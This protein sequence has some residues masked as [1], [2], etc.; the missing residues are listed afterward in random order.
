MNLIDV[1]DVVRLPIDL[2]GLGEIEADEDTASLPYTFTM[3]C[4]DLSE[5]LDRVGGGFLGA[6][7]IPR[8]C[9][10]RSPPMM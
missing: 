7:P 8:Y 5:T 9:P 10:L 3:P 1:M 2:S 4:L 6:H